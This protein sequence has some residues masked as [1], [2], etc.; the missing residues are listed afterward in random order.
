LLGEEVEGLAHYW[1][2][3]VRLLEIYG[4]STR[5][6]WAKIPRIRRAMADPVYNEYITKRER[7]KQT[8][9]RSGQPGLPFP[10]PPAD[11]NDADDR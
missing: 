1:R 3:L 10:D 11:A 6:G 9:P 7:P 4:H 5:G 2:D 8:A